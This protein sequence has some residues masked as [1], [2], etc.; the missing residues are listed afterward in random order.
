M[1]QM[2]ETSEP[3]PGQEQFHRFNTI[4]EN[5]FLLRK[6]PMTDHQ[7]HSP[8]PAGF[9]PRFLASV[10]DFTLVF[11][12]IGTLILAYLAMEFSSLALD[13]RASS[14]HV[15]SRAV[16]DSFLS[17]EPGLHSTSGISAA[18][19]FLILMKWFILIIMPVYLLYSAGFEASA[20]QATPGKTAMHLIVTDRNGRPLGIFHSVGRTAAKIFCIIPLGLG[21]LPLLFSG[22]G[23]GLHDYCTRTR[24]MTGEPALQADAAALTRSDKI[25]QGILMA[26]LIILWTRYWFWL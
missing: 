15:I 19:L 26:I 12:L 11:G 23:M 7:I 21:F 9:L 8:G 24:V 14:S 4:G 1:K 2:E 5:N 25:F 17:L 18:A 16:D 22:N 13:M 10:I 20:R 6:I 3:Y